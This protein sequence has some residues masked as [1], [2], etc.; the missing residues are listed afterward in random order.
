MS[1]S[2][3][4]KDLKVGQRLYY[5][6]RSDRSRAET[7]TVHKIGRSWITL[8]QYGRTDV[9][10]DKETGSAELRGGYSL[11]G[12]LY[13]SE[14][15]HREESA[16]ENLWRQISR[17][18]SCKVPPSIPSED[19]LAI[20]EKLRLEKVIDSDDYRLLAQSKNTPESSN[21]P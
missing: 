17:V 18:T 9:R 20:V 7:F 3:H 14:A 19:I 4:T 2:G 15:H 13:L 1:L 11:D 16:R 6:P 5:R 21:C 10:V 8:E 12:E